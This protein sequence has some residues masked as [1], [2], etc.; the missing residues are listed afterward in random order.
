[1][2]DISTPKVFESEVIK[3]NVYPNGF[4]E[5]LIKHNAMFDSAAIISS[6][7]F[8]TSELKEKKAYILLELEGEVFTTKEAREL[9]ASPE[10]SNHHGAIAF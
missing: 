1:M 10:H 3:L 4:V 9:A 2:G 6:K 8:I 7:D 5:L